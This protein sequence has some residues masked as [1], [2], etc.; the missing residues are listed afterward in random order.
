MTPTEK[1]DQDVEEARQDVFL[2]ASKDNIDRLVAAV[3]KHDAEL[4]RETRPEVSDGF[5][6][7]AGYK[8]GWKEGTSGAAD[9]LIGRT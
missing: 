2:N 8:L 4:V 3:R 9:T 1:A 6:L 7:T 5:V